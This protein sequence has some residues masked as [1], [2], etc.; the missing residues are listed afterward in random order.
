M[1][2]KFMFAI[3]A[4]ACFCAPVKAADWNGPIRQIITCTD[5]W[6]EVELAGKTMPYN[7][8]NPLVRLMV[9]SSV[10][11]VDKY[12]QLYALSLTAFSTDASVWVGTQQPNNTTSVTGGNCNSNNTPAQVVGGM[13]VYH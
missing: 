7:G 3:A 4:A 12:K 8:G 2:K 9:K 10:V 6:F 13:A 11:G 5:T 1:F